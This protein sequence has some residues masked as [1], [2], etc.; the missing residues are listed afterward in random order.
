MKTS[1]EFLRSRRALLAATL[2]VLGCVLGLLTPVQ[3]AQSA[4]CAFSPVI[5]TY[6]SN[7]TYTTVVGQRGRDCACEP[8]FWGVTSAYVKS[9]TLCCSVNTC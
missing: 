1:P 3:D 8:V 2:V 7:A 6:Y 4:I 5:R 9:Q